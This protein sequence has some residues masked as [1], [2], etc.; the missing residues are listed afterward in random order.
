MSEIDEETIARL[1]YERSR[2]SPAD[3]EIWE[4]ADHDVRAWL[5]GHARAV[6]AL[7]HPAIERARVEERERAAKRIDEMAANLRRRIKNN[8]HFD[9]IETSA[10]RLDQQAAAIRKT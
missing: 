7:V 1:L 4:Q 6:L 3:P 5:L 8:H 9:D 2:M 10:K